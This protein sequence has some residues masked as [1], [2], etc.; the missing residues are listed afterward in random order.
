MWLV[1]NTYFYSCKPTKAL[2]RIFS[3]AGIEQHRDHYT[4]ASKDAYALAES[5]ITKAQA[6][7]VKRVF[8]QATQKLN[9]KYWGMSKTRQLIVS[10]SFAPGELN[11]RPDYSFDIRN[12]RGSAYFAVAFTLNE[13]NGKDVASQILSDSKKMAVYVSTCDFPY[14]TVS[15]RVDTVYQFQ[16]NFAV[17]IDEMSM[18]VLRS[19]AEFGN[20]DARPAA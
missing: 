14:K 15:F 8:I 9:E 10:F 4:W 17:I 11:S 6:S 5:A 19:F 16:D 2:M 3:A 13:K 18:Q 20:T 12:E 7:T 1:G